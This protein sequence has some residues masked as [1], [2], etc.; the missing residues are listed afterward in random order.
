MQQRRILYIGAHPDDADIL[1]GGTAYQLTHAGHLVKFISVTNGDTGHQTL[2][3]K[4]TA[5]VRPVS[6]VKNA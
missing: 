6:S 1:F 5:A 3:R 2:S 4:Q